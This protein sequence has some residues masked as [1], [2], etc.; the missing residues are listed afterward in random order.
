ML[1]LLFNFTP[2]KLVAEFI[3]RDEAFSYFMARENLM[4]IVLTTARDNN[5]PLYYILLHFWMKIF[6]PSSIAMRSLSMIFFAVMIYFCYLL[7]KRLLKVSDKKIGIYLVLIFFNPFLLYYAFEA[8][9]YSLFA[10]LCICSYYFFINKDRLKVAIFNTLG[11]YTHYFFLMVILSQ[12]I[13]LAI[14]ER[15]QF[16]KYAKVLI[17]PLI[18]AL[19]WFLYI[20]K[21][22]LG[23]TAVFWAQRLQFSSVVESLAVLLTG[24]ESAYYSYYDKYLWM[25]SIYLLTLVVFGVF[26]LKTN[27][28]TKML[29]IWSFLFYYLVVIISFFKP[30]FVPRYL[31]FSAV[32]FN[33][34]MIYII[35]GLSKKWSILILISIFVIYIHYWWM[36][37]IYRPKA[38]EVKTIMEIKKIASDKDLLYLTDPILYFTARYYFDEKRVYLYNLDPKKKQSYYGL[39]LIPKESYINLLPEYP[40]KAFIMSSEDNFKI[41]TTL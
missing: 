16:K 28:T 41:E 21:W 12:I 24:Y 11:I 20:Y 15:H 30:I 18:L 7:L 23:N 36:L 1:N 10:V 13:Y 33:V 14:Y 37:L 19:P 32:G 35:N 8:R 17:L 34:L 31:I 27:K 3:W 4:N 40:V 29:L 2:L 9:M 38:H 22:L 6:G 39:V 25:V 5:P 26:R